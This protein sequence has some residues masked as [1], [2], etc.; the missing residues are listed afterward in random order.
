REFE[1]GPPI[2]APIAMRL[3][4]ESLDTLRTLAERVEQTLVRGAGT[5]Y[6]VNPMRVNRTDLHLAVDRQK[7]GL[8]GVPSV[9]IDRTLRLGIAGLTAGQLRA[10]DEVG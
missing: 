4:G 9:E 2:D 3:T 5:Q 1:N 8:L 7:A 10:S 6:V